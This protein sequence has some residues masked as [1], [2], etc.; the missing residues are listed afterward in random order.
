M[1]PFRG[2][3]QEAAIVPSQSFRA[4]CQA[5]TGPA[6]KPEHD[7]DEPRSTEKQHEPRELSVGCN[8]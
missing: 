6:G 1:S 5:N 4:Y 8:Y 2:Q 3:C 7:L